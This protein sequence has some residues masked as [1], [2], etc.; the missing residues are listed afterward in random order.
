MRK[1]FDELFNE[2]FNRKRNNLNTVQN[3]LQKIIESLMN[4]KQI[5]VENLLE[6]SIEAELGEPNII[7]EMEEN[8]VI[9]R[10][11]IWNT[12]YGN[13]VKIIVL[14]SEYDNEIKKQSPKIKQKSPEEQLK[15]AVES[16]N[17]EL[18]IE[19]RDKI[20]NTKKPRRTKTKKD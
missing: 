5:D 13:F 15:E 12:P 17:Y 11:L 20:K 4:F 10:K 3:E 8:G 19:L 2:F 6:K 9:L 14:D 18:A 7:Q 1:T 16:E